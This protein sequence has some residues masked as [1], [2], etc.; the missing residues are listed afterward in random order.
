MALPLDSASFPILSLLLDEQQPWG[1]GITAAHIPPS[2]GQM[3][4]L[5][6]QLVGSG[7]AIIQNV[8]RDSDDDMQ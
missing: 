4:G 8:P 7:T 6:P 1:G 2:G 3:V 5:A